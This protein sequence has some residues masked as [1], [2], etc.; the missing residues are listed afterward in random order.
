MDDLLSV[1]DARI[2]GL[3]SAA[4]AGHT[5]K[6]V[7][8]E[9]AAE[10]LDL[11]A[12]RAAVDRRLPAGSRGRDRVELG[13]PARWVADEAFAIAD[14]VRR[15]ESTGGIDELGAWQAAAALMSQRLDHER[16]LWRFDVIGPF[17][18]GR[19]AI[20]CRIHHAMADGI[21]SV[22][23]LHEVLWDEVEPAPASAPPAS[24]TAVDQEGER[25]RL[26][27]ELAR[28]PGAVVREL[29]HRASD[30]VLDRRIGA[31][32]ELA[33]SAVPLSKLKAV[34]SSLPGHVTVNDVFLA[35]VAGGLRGWLEHAGERLPRLRA[36]I[37]VSLHH[38]AEGADELGNRDSFMNVE[39]PVNEADPVARALAIN[40]QTS[41]RKRHNDAE[42]LY[43]LFH[44]LARY[45]HLDRAAERLAG[46]PREFSLSISNVP[47][48]GCELAVAGRRVESLYSVA[49]PA[50]RH[51]LRISAISCSG[52]IGIGLC[53][54]PEAVAG[55]DTL[56]VAIGD[57][58]AELAEATRG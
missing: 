54:D 24:R 8:L 47:G 1:D 15:D 40:A 34:G 2:L 37:P 23:F 35:G 26:A 16:P 39:L 58:M 36:Q 56:A 25:R 49:E 14:H 6:L 43:D 57:S 42:E 44:A 41:T 10:A 7:V 55:I 3:E 22:R 32:R 20:V 27:A 30:T 17:A 11:D 12:L 9:A 53:T 52:E 48:P 50:D 51:A 13:P 5:L 29:G 33:F 38:R 19:E 28:M 46:G 4:I 45:K 18:D 21:S 31:A